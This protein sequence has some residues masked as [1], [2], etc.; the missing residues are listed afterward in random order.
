MVF[1]HKSFRIAI[2]LSNYHYTAIDAQ[3]LIEAAK[4]S[5]W[6]IK[7]P[8]TNLL[9]LLRNNGSVSL[10]ILNEQIDRM[11]LN[12]IITVIVEFLYELWREYK[13][14]QISNERRDSLVM[15]MLNAMV[16]HRQNRN[17]IIR[18]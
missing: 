17:A 6:L 5:D 9:N 3:V 12:S 14:Q 4:K 2:V 16:H 11:S 13:M 1:S 18:K 10:L 7:R 15:E 8:F